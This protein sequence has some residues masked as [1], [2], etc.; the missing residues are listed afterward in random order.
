MNLHFFEGFST[1]PIGCQAAILQRKTEREAAVTHL[2]LARTQNCRKRHFGIF[3][4]DAVRLPS[5]VQKINGQVT[6]DFRAQK[7]HKVQKVFKVQKKNHNCT[8][9]SIQMREAAFT[10]ASFPY[11]CRKAKRDTHR[12]VSLLLPKGKKGYP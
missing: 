12:G 11:Y 3:R 9:D 7:I 8:H 6:K 2:A 10:A 5:G 4:E 1:L